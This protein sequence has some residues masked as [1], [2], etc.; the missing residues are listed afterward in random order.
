MYDDAFRCEPFSTYPRTYDLIHVA[1]M[2][3]L[4]KDPVSGKSRYDCIFSMI[5]LLI[6]LLHHLNNTSNHY[7]YGE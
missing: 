2:E 1:A 7:S 4:I 5:S 6:E 3:S